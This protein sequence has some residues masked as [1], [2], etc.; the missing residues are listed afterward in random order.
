[1]KTLV[2]LAW[3]GVAVDPAQGIPHQMQTWALW[4]AAIAGGLV[5]AQQIAT[6][7]ALPAWRGVRVAQR[8]AREAVRVAVGLPAW[9]EKVDAAHEEFRAAHKRSAA[10]HLVQDERLDRVEATLRALGDEERKLIERR[11][12]G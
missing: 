3:L 10:A 11:L 6:R 5:A 12:T 9:M 2:V 4:L 7:F 1:M 8:E